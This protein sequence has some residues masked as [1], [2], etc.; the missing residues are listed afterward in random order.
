MTEPDLSCAGPTSER[1]STVIPPKQRGGGGWGGLGGWGE[2]EGGGGG[3]VGV[4][5]EDGGGLG[6]HVRENL[7]RHTT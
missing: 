2:G 3:R 7:Q 6:S 4:R 1:T 5:L